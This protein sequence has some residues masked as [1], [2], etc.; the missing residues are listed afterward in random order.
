VP[1]VGQ[2]P[3]PADKRRQLDGKGCSAV[4]G[5]RAIAAA[6]IRPQASRGQMENPV[7]AAQVLQPVH[8]QVGQRGA[9]GEP[10]THQRGCRL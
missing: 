9:L 5:W 4:P 3:V 1:D 10:V 8:P 6:G 2:F 7:R